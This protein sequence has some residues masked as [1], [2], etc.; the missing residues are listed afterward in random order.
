[1]C[2]IILYNKHLLIIFTRFPMA[3]KHI[4][5]SADFKK[6]VLG[7]SKP[8]LVDFYAEWC[9]PCKIMAPV[10]EEISSE[11]PGVVVVKVDVDA[12]Q[13]I[14]SEY[15]ISSI[16]TFLMFVGGSVVGQLVGAVGKAQIKKMI[17]SAS[18]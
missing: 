3:T 1:M 6:E 14:A 8:V 18:P 11:T 5:T 15:N 16:P 4:T 12:N 9:G 13:D 17:S 2:G 7:S 10:L